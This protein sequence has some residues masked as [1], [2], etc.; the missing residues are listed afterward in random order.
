MQQTS[1]LQGSTLVN[2]TVN[3]VAK[4]W[5]L[6]TSGPVTFDESQSVDTSDGSKVQHSITMDYLTGTAKYSIPIT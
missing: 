4:Q 3:G 1:N 2:A 5:T 6:N